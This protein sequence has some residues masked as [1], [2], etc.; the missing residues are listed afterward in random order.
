MSKICRHVWYICMVVLIGIAMIIVILINRHKFEWYNHFSLVTRYSIDPQNMI[1]NQL[2]SIRLT[3]QTFD[4][5]LRQDLTNDKIAVLLRDPVY[6]YIP[7]NSQ[8]QPMNWS[9]LFKLYVDAVT[10][11]S[12]GYLCGGL[13]FFYRILLEAFGI[14]SRYVELLTSIGEKYDSHA[15]VEV[16]IDG[17]WVA[18]DP[19]FNLMIK[20]GKKYI[21]YLELASVL[22]QQGDFEL[23]TNGM[24]NSRYPADDVIFTPKS[25][26][27]NF[28]FI[29][30]A[31]VSQPGKRIKFEAI[32]HPETWN[33]YI[34]GLNLNYSKTD[35]LEKYLA[36]GILR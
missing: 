1:R 15:S 6:N 21:S 12:A 11:S 25:S 14:P 24:D 31:T 18:S 5:R 19:T 22:T 30:P 17:K 32:K 16:F 34:R 13:S 23:A 35:I 9:N 2:I 20:S 33:G 27:F 28:I 3:A 26:Y 36:D 8:S 10:G 29:G 7:R 4:K